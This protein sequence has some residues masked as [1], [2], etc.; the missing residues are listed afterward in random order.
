MVLHKTQPILA[1]AYADILQNYSAQ[2]GKAPML[3]ADVFY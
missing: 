1:Q 2:K 3:L